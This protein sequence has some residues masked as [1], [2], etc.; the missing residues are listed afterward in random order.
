MPHVLEEVITP[1]A[2]SKR[3][4]H[5]SNR[6][7]H[8]NH[9]QSSNHYSNH[10]SHILHDNQLPNPYP[11][12]SHPSPLGRNS[13]SEREGGGS[14]VSSLVKELPRDGS[15]PKMPRQEKEA[16]RAPSGVKVTVLNDDMRDVI[17]ASEMSKPESVT[18]L[19]KAE[20]QPALMDALSSRHVGLSAPKSNSS[21]QQ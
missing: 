9:Q 4:A 3:G 12:N 21:K 16:P 19:A 5:H 14:R 18:K 20:T 7:N 11:S 8:S 13:P 10:Y 6:S 17:S 1:A 2:K 15:L